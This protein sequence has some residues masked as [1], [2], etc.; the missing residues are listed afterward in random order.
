MNN[1]PFV[2]MYVRR[3][4]AKR[5]EWVPHEDITMRLKSLRDYQEKTKIA[6]KDL[7][8]NHDYN[9]ILI[10]FN[11]M[12]ELRR[13]ENHFR[14]FLIAEVGRCRFADSLMYLL[15]LSFCCMSY[16]YNTHVGFTCLIHICRLMLLVQDK[17]VML[18]LYHLLRRIKCQLKINSWT[19]PTF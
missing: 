11:T 5:Y 14:D 6:E 19:L 16:L 10:Y 7:V 17:I 3:E 1:R 8:A 9:G 18:Q 13:E 2:P 12:S 15:C 4:V